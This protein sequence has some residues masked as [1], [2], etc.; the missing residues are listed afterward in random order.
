MATVLSIVIALALAAGS[1]LGL[2]RVHQVF[3]RPGW[4]PAVLGLFF[5]VPIIVS[6][7]Q[8]RRGRVGIRAF[9]RSLLAASGGLLALT[10]VRQNWTTSWVWACLGGVVAEY[11]VVIVQGFKI[12]QARTS[13]NQSL[14]ALNAGKV[15]VALKQAQVALDIA[16]TKGERA[17]CAEAEFIAGFCYN[18]LGESV[19][20]ARYLGRSRADFGPD[21]PAARLKQID[22]LL[23]QLSS[24]GGDVEAPAEPGEAG[25]VAEGMVGQLTV[26]ALLA[27]AA[28][29]ACLKLWDVAAL[30]ASVWALACVGA[31]VVLLAVGAY[32]TADLGIARRG[33]GGVAALLPLF[34]IGLLA[35]AG[36]AVALLLR[37]GV[38]VVAE[39]PMAAQPLLADAGRW[40]AWAVAA[41]TAAGA[42]TAVLAMMAA[43]GRSPL[44]LI[45]R[46]GDST[47]KTMRLA[48]SYLD[49]GEWGKAVAQLSR[50]DLINEKDVGRRAE[51]L[52]LL[53][54]AHHQ[55]GHPHDAA[56][57]VGELLEI[58]PDHR[59]GLYLA[60][61]LAL[62]AN[63]LDRAESCWRRLHA[64]APAYR[65]ADGKGRGSAAYYLC[66]TL[67]RKAMAVMTVDVGQGAQL[68]AEVG[69]LGALDNEVADALARVHLH[70]FVELARHGDW[71]KAA[72]E[73]EAAQG[74]LAALQEAGADPTDTAKIRGFALAAQGLTAFHGERHA[75]AAAHFAEALE[76][77]KSLRQTGSFG[78]KG[79]TLLEQLL[80]S[81]MEGQS[82][83]QSINP[84]FPRDAGFLAAVA[85]LNRLQGTRT[86]PAQ[87]TEALDRIQRPLS[88]ALAAAPDAPEVLALLGLLWYH[89][90]AD[91]DMQQKGIE[92]L[93]RVRERV[94]SKFVSQ[95]V[96]DYE[97]D[98]Q[99]L[100]DARQAY[101]DLLRQHLRSAD[102]P[103]ERREA[104]QAEVLERLKERGEYE[105]LVGKGSLEAEAAEEPSVQEY[106][107][108]AQ[109]LNAKV[110]QALK[111]KRAAALSP[112]VAALMDKL[113]AQNE[114]L[115]QTVGSITELEAQI[116]QE[117]LGLL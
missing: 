96:A 75:Q 74:K 82:D 84:S 36:G 107:N 108:R 62:V 110:R 59:E 41:V 117:A 70:R 66:L 89:L 99:V 12:M 104:L 71:V 63:E 105:S 61:Y 42:L 15:D 43:A 91:E 90:G 92:A 24:R 83:R 111:T 34:A 94:A 4:L 53:A 81:L 109:L 1:W 85:E 65:A 22:Q 57:H 51:T 44:G 103:A 64:A 69:R 21:G 60:G 73:A 14:Q 54:F 87:L 5:A 88:D 30:R 25:R 18:N 93:Q 100:K 35:A 114:S 58:A 37:Q 77:T 112:Q 47:D 3:P 17:I 80:R 50:V 106:V 6:A 48:R 11:L 102:V 33:K 86:T 31:V 10:L 98:Q 26:S 27:T 95:T 72:L 116:L 97:S 29:L 79:G 68:L 52:F 45:T 13:L 7:L 32:V 49:G 8:L 39:F 40:P 101:F 67:Y 19:R 46:I 113:D 23:E 76:A 56:G 2:A 38:L 20:A 55:A 16:V 78:G 115:Q 28:A 9:A